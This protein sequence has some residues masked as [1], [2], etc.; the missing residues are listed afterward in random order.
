MSQKEEFGMRLEKLLGEAKHL[1]VEEISS[2]SKL[3][4]IST[5]QNLGLANHFQEEIKEAL[6]TTL[7]FMNNNNFNKVHHHEDVYA[8]AQS[9]RILRQNGYAVS[10]GLSL[11]TYIIIETKS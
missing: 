1:F 3:E 4:L 2:L 10:P 5:I 11:S 6:G 9:F 7:T 8:N